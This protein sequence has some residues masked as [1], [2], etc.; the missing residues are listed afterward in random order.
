M[1]IIVGKGAWDLRDCKTWQRVYICHILCLWGSQSSHVA[2]LPI[3]QQELS[4]DMLER[5][6]AIA[7]PGT[8]PS[9]WQLHNIA[10]FD[11]LSRDKIFSA[12][13]VPGYLVIQWNKP[14]SISICLLDRKTLPLKYGLFHFCYLTTLQHGAGTDW[15]FKCFVSPCFPKQHNGLTPFEQGPHVMSW[16]F[17]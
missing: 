11:I 15:D 14:W 16:C 7:G 4:S 3:F 12:V 1:F 5:K 13:Q 10:I 6:V 17:C 8:G 2:H 9:T